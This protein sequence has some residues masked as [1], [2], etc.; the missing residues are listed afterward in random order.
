M[1]KTEVNGLDQRAHFYLNVRA[2]FDGRGLPLVA[3]PYRNG[4]PGLSPTL[5]GCLAGRR[6]CG[7]ETTTG[8]KSRMSGMGRRLWGGEGNISRVPSRRRISFWPLERPAWAGR[9]ES[10]AE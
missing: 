5:P 7:G 1:T 4:P 9:W 2:G 3:L 6:F 8:K 10:P